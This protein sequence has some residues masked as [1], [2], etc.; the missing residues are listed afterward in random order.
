MA[1]QARTSRPSGRPSRPSIADRLKTGR[2]IARGTVAPAVAAFRDPARLTARLWLA[3]LRSDRR[4]RFSTA[5]LAGFVVVAVI[6]AL[7]PPLVGRVEES[8]AA[9]SPV[10]PFGTDATGRDVL[11]VLVEGTTG[12]LLGGIGAALAAALVGIALGVLGGFLRGTTDAFV[13][14][15]TEAVHAIP[16]LFFVLVLQA[17]APAPGPTTVLLAI[18]ATRWTEFARVV[19][20]DVLRVLDMDHVT[21]ARALGASPSRILARHVLPSV[22][23]SALVLVAF[24]VGAVVIVEAAVAVVGVGRIDPL[25]W[26]ALLA[27]AR[28]NPRAWWLVVFPALL[29]AVVVS[30]ASLLGEAMRDALDP[31]LRG[32]TGER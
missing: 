22:I 11:M 5:V 29:I 24:S 30:A 20:A 28:P 16:A 9:P 18:V 17:V 7:A 31:K 10:H 19:R 2:D 23:S 25:S 1:E 26:G 4:A 8:L 32:V 6:G 3:A 21:A 12:T 15:L 14:R 13:H 27:E